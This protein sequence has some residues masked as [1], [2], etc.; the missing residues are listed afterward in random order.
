MLPKASR[1]RITEASG[2]ECQQVLSQENL[3]RGQSGFF[4]FRDKE[5]QPKATL[6][7]RAA[8]GQEARVD[9]NS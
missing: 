7:E 3:V 6:A 8:G 9:T 5:T 1:R 2:L 4:Y